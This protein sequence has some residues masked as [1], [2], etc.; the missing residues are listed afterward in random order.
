MTSGSS[1]F[2]A[3]EGGGKNITTF[4]DYILKGGGGGRFVQM[5]VV[6]GNW[7]NLFKTSSHHAMHLFKVVWITVKKIFL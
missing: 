2:C 1:G 7:L 3:N 5:E 4:E 6:D